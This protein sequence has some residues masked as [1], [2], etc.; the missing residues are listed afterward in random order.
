MIVSQVINL[1]RN[2]LIE[3]VCQKYNIKSWNLAKLSSKGLTLEVRK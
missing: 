1:D 2:E 3:L